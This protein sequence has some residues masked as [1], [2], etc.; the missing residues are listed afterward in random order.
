MVHH[1]I[2][3]ATYCLP[4]IRFPKTPNHYTFTLKVATEMFAKTLDRS[5]HSTRLIPKSQSYT[6]VYPILT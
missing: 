5:Q 4:Y 2:Q 1:Q 6:Q 3:L